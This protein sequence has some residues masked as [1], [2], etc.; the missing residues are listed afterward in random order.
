M[1]IELDPTFE[2]CSPSLWSLPIVKHN[3]GIQVSHKLNPCF[4]VHTTFQPNSGP[5]TLK[6]AN[7]TDNSIVICKSQNG[8]SQRPPY[9]YKR[10]ASYSYLGV[11]CIIN[12]YNMPFKYIKTFLVMLFSS[13]N[14]SFIP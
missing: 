12:V 3:M 8:R 7:F 10:E 1:V 2:E 4:Y 6:C 11:R 9:A 14:F 13:L 5:K